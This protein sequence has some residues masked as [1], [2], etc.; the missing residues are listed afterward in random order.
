AV[1]LA[2]FL[3]SVPLGR[4]LFPKG[5]LLWPVPSAERVLNG[6][7]N[8]T[9]WY[10]SCAG[11]LS[12]FAFLSGPVP[13][14][15]RAEVLIGLIS[16]LLT[17]AAGKFPPLGRA[18]AFCLPLL[19]LRFWFVDMASDTTEFRLGPNFLFKGASAALL[20]VILW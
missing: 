10:F 16:L 2:T 18:I 14:S 5:S 1:T 3:L 6:I 17:W 13:L 11:A 12:L 7:I 20:L 19:L 4:F 15:W 9:L 8:W